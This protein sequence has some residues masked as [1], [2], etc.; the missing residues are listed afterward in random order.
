MDTA[1]DQAAN[2]FYNRTRATLEGA[3]LRPRHDGYMAFQVKVAQLIT[4]GL[5][6]KAPAKGLVEDINRVA[7]ETSLKR[8]P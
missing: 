4:E 8:K 6:A 1:V 7:R 2:G 5:L 3:I